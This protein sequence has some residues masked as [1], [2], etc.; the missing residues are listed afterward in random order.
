MR[1][2]SLVLLSLLSLFQTSSAEIVAEWQF[3]G[4]E[5]IAPGGTIPLDLVA[6]KASA[7]SELSSRSEYQAGP[8]GIS[9]AWQPWLRTGYLVLPSGVEKNGAGLMTKAVSE[10][11]KDARY[12]RYMGK[13]G[14]GGGTFYA[15]VCPTEDWNA[16]K[17]RGIMGTG[18]SIEGYLALSVEAG[19]ISFEAGGIRDGQRQRAV[20]RAAVRFTP[21]KWLFIGA[22]WLAGRNPVLYLR[23]LESTTE[24]TG[25]F[26][27]VCGDYGQPNYDP[28]AIGAIWT[29]TGS[30]AGTID[31]LGGKIAWARFENLPSQLAEMQ[32]VFAGLRANATVPIAQKKTESKVEFKVLRHAPCNLFD[33]AEPV[34]FTAEL[35]GAPAGSGEVQAVIVDE[36]KKEV[37]RMNFAISTQPDKPATIPV[38]LGK[39][40]RGYYELSLH[41][42][43]K[44]DQGQLTGGSAHCSFGVMQFSQR[45]AREALDYKFGLKW[46]GGIENQAE[47]AEA[48]ARLGLQWTRII[49]NEGGGKPGRLSPAQL[50]GDHQLNGVIKIERFPKELYDDVRYGPMEEWEKKYGRG[51]WTIKSLPKKEPYQLWLKEQ[52]SSVI[53]ADQK[54]FEIWNE[55]WDKMA[56]EDFAQLSQWIVEVILRERPDAII[57][58]NFLG[59]TS[60][61]EY[62]ARVIQAG[63]MKGMKMVA[64]HPY[65]ASENREWLRNYRNWL[66][67]KTGREMEIYITEYGSHSTPQ[68]PARRSEMEQARRQVRQSLA[69]YAEGV[70]ALIPHWAGQSEQNPTYLEDWFGFVRKNEEPKPVL[71][72]HANC[73]RLIDHSKYLGDLWFGPEVAAMLFEKEGKHILALWTL[74]QT[75]PAGENSSS[76]EIEIDPAADSF[77]LTDI[78]GREKAISGKLKLKLDES[79]IYLVGVGPELAKKASKELRADRWPKPEKAPRTIRATRKLAAPPVYDGKFGDWNGSVQLALLNP[80]VNGYDCSGTGYVAWDDHFLYVGTDLR[81]NELR[82]TES[83]NKLYRHDS[84]ELFVSSEPRDEGS[85]FGPN[86][87]QFILTA[88]SGEGKP[89]IGEVTDREAGVVKEIAGAEFFAGPTHNTDKGWALEVALPWSALPGFKPAP[90]ARLALEVRV[91]DADTSH[92]RFK[93]DPVDASPDFSVS[94]PCTWSLL[95]LER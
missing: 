17:R 3:N 28:L 89:V 27:S 37:S 72:A 65:A 26:D 48:M 50:L 95:S 6:P 41:A 44:D 52:L 60:P 5:N 12:G 39:L 93:I 15:V 38:A 90:G 82:N 24:V 51:S 80:K 87:H 56:P 8:T 13:A 75:A 22:S 86:D 33:A 67:E 34:L 76:R 25:A 29:N 10:D 9:D 46:W 40:G 32:A 21:G 66:K 53:P 70:S 84:M 31:G 83:R 42:K 35:R 36:A 11:K 1:S 57:G 7:V 61:Y 92:E 64:L 94:N 79:P 59:N 88:A 19:T 71:L 68:G 30:E 4:S 85:G 81:D 14:M 54:V 18:H 45:T 73:A 20:S 74:S 78:L 63:G 55:P 77:I 43:V 47:M 62:D 58:P 69:L 49:Q 23:E 16:G 91:N 2:S